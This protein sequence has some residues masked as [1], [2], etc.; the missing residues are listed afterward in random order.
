M[1][2]EKIIMIKI[3]DT[4]HPWTKDICQCG[5]EYYVTRSYGKVV[6]R[7][8]MYCSG[9]STAFKLDLQNKRVEELEK[10]LKGMINVAEELN[11]RLSKTDQSEGFYRHIEDAKNLLEEE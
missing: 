6:T 10:S 9:C 1:L 4:V 11:Y 8:D 2:K 3:G 7:W 5:E